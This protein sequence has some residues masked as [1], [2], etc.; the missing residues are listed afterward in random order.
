M[1][2]A[3][4]ILLS[5]LFSIAFQVNS[6][7]LVFT[8]TKKD[9]EM[10]KIEIKNGQTTLHIK[11]AGG[12]FTHTWNQVPVN[13]DNSN[14]R[15][16]HKMIVMQEEDDRIVSFEIVYVFIKATNSYTCQVKR[17]T[18]FKNGDEAISSN[19][20]FIGKLN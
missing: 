20:H 5:L 3:F 8:N 10:E 1:K 6:G 15:S 17:V 18:T 13:F 14:G 16:R 7:H 9:A 12:K 4:L 2:E 19:D 11:S